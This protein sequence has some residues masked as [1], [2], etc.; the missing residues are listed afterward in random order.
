[1]EVDECCSVDQW[2]HGSVQQQGKQANRKELYDE[3]FL[4]H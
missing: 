4:F 1:M 2:N 3:L